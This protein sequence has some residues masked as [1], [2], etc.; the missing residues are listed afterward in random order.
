MYLILKIEYDGT[1]Y[2]GW[3]RQN[4]AITI[5]GEIERAFREISGINSV[6]MG[7]G[8]TDAGVHARAQIAHTFLD[9]DLNISA[10]QLPLAINSKLNY[11][12]RVKSAMLRDEEFHS[13]FDAIARE[14]VYTIVTDFS[15]FTRHFCNHVRYPLSIDL[16]FESASIFLRK[17]DFTT[18]SKI[19]SDI[20]NN[21]CDVSISRWEKLTDTMYRYR[22]KANHFL[23]GMVRS[24][25][26]T[27]LDI[28][29]G[30]RTLDDAAYALE[31]KNRALQSP[32]AEAR[33]LVLE[34]I[35]YKN[36]TL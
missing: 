8:R 12:I 4:N 21:V 35:Y 15:V 1:N 32:L 3:Q 9:K 24:L 26:G 34:K 14:Y 19:N 7:A 30:K 31:Q 25:V 5:Q 10:E 20:I 23:Y 33:G 11:D 18:Y 6:F 36:L 22:I 28:A 16:L 13:R 27:M 17:T 2:S 29:R